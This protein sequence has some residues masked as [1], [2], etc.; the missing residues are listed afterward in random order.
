MIAL[1]NDLMETMN[2]WNIPNITPIIKQTTT[3]KVNE[4]ISLFIVYAT[5]KDSINLTYNLRLLEPN[6][7]FSENGHNGLIISNKVINKDILYTAAQLPTI[8][9]E[10]EEEIGE[11]HFVIEVYD[12]DEFIKT[13]ILKFSL[14]E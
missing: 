11:Y 8:V 6:G 5:N 14:L 9:F 13:F 2:I 3:V 10:E 4:Q 7:E 12:N 1:V